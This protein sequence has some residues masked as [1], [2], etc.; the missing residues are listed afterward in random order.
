MSKT[1][2]SDLAVTFRSVP[3]RLGEAY[4][5]DT[6]AAGTALEAQLRRAGG[7]LGTSGDAAGIADAIAGTPADQWDPAVLDGLRAIALEVGHE[8]RRIAAEH[9]AD[10]DT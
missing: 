10:E 8:L 9:R 7:L 4:G 6:P 1:S 5:D 2:P 3:R